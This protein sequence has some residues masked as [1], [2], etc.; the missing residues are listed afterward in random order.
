M[1]IDDVARTAQR[2]SVLLSAG[3]PPA[4]AWGYLGQQ[5]PEDIPAALEARGGAWHGLA[6]AWRVAVAAGSPLAP[7]LARYAESLRSLGEAQRETQIALAGPRASSRLVLALPPVGLVFGGL[8]GF[9]T[10]HT[11]FATPGGLCCL[12][13]GLALLF[14]GTLWNRRLLRAAQPTELAPGLA[15]DLMA[16]AVTGG[17]SLQSAR[18]L[19][20]PLVPNLEAVDDVLQL[21]SAA[22]VP[23]ATLL[24]AEAEESRRD[25]TASAKRAAA[26]LAVR[27]M[28][29][30]GICV[31]PAFMLLAVAPLMISVISSTV[32]GVGTLSP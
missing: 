32:S 11:L 13:A 21:S 25:A 2:L 10:L 18:E 1:S 24:I 29:P 4:S 17:G 26:E 20:S 27:L 31:L 12:V 23:A 8:L 28:L 5:L 30:L 9:D 3:V 7:C 15:F 6:S 22:G 14:A 19:V 16:I